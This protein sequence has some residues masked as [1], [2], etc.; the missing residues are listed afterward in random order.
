[1]FGARKTKQLYIDNT[2]LTSWYQGTISTDDDI[3]KIDTKN[4]SSILIESLENDSGLKI[5]VIKPI[6]STN[7]QYLVFINKTDNTLWSLDLTK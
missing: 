1:V 3:W 7:E 5:D 6:L 2:S 4:N